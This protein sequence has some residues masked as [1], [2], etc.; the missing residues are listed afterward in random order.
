MENFHNLN[1]NFAKFSKYYKNSV[2][3]ANF[4]N[5]IVPVYPVVSRLITDSKL[6]FLLSVEVCE[7]IDWQITEEEQSIQHK[8]RR[9]GSFIVVHLSKIKAIS[10]VFYYFLFVCLQEDFN[11]SKA[12]P[13]SR[14]VF[15]L[16]QL[17]SLGSCP[18]VGSLD[19]W[20]FPKWVHSLEWPTALFAQPI[21]CQHLLNCSLIQFVLLLRLCNSSVIPFD[22]FRAV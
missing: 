14:G 12:N 2:R 8:N 20:T 11:V 3:Q 16:I 18:R 19:Q 7:C 4:A 15:L 6:V 10:I 1:W 9:H 17:I 22:L 13:L 21:A 5:K